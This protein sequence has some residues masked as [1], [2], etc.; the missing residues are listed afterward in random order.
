M[1]ADDTSMLARA[2]E[3]A[4]LVEA[5]SAALNGRYRYTLSGS[6]VTVSDGG[7]WSRKTVTTDTG[8]VKSEP[9][10]VVAQAIEKGWYVRLD[11]APD[12]AAGDAP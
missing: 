10:I 1:A 9:S 5:A 2:T 6:I 12:P 8:D 7:D 11:D 3:L 4:G